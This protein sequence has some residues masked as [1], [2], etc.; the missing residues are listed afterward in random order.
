MR[1]IFFIV[2]SLML[3]QNILFAAEPLKTK[4]PETAANFTLLDLDNKEFSLSEFKGKPV[5]LFFWTTWCPYCRK[6]LKELNSMQ[7]EL[8][9]DGVQVAAIN[10]E[11]PLDKVRKFIGNNPFFFPVL[12]DT[13]TKVADA[14][15]ILGVPTYFFINKEGRIVFNSHYF[16]RK[17]YKDLI[18]K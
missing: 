13:D 10:V 5:I 1:K 11:E 3:V 8:L 2:L 18:L 6:E 14:Y 4:T 7:T 16:P 15:G 12:L 9:K 17:E